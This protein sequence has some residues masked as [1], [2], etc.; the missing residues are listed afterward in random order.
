[1]GDKYLE[2]IEDKPDN[3]HMTDR[4]SDDWVYLK[5]GGDGEDIAEAEYSC[6]NTEGQETSWN[7][8]HTNDKNPTL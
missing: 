2:N 3:H 7:L 4:N 1:M 5:A 8:S 6:T